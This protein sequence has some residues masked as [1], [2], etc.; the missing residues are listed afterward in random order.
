MLS[1]HLYENEDKYK[2]IRELVHKEVKIRKE[3]LEPFFFEDTADD[4]LVN[5]KLE[6]YIERI[7]EDCFY[8]GII[9]IGII[10][11]YY[12]INIS[13]YC[14]DNNDPNQYVHFTNIWKDERL[15]NFMI[16]HYNQRLEYFSILNFNG[17][18]NP[19][20]TN[21]I[22][23]NHSKPN[24]KKIIIDIKDNKKENMRS[25]TYVKINNNT[26]YY[27]DIYNYLYSKKQSLKEKKI[28]WKKVI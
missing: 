24:F 9:E 8:G 18:Q 3:E 1:L 17:I 10:S 19:P 5:T 2:E 25:N 15:N 21:Q 20:S 13:V 6:N 16:L 26:N 4:T 11:N 23:I 28:V 14:T 27:N 12:D 22:I 7:K